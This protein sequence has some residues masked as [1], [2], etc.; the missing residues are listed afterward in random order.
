MFR[1]KLKIIQHII[2]ILD[3]KTKPQPK[4]FTL[5]IYKLFIFKQWHQTTFNRIPT[6]TEVDILYMI[7]E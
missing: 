3:I 6:T 4:L 1:I 2:T 7:T 5:D